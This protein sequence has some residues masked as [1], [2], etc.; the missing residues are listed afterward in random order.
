MAEHVSKMYRVEVESH[1]HER[2]Y[3]MSGFCMS[4][5]E[6]DQSLKIVDENMSGMSSIPLSLLV[7]REEEAVEQL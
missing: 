3:G 7:R 1:P 4:A 6:K 2:F 5:S